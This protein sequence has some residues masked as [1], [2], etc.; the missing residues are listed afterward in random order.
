[1]AGP[2]VCNGRENENGIVSNEITSEAKGTT[3]GAEETSLPR[4]IVELI[5][6]SILQG[7]LSPGEHL[8]QSMLASQ[9][10]ISKVPVREALKQLDAEGLLQHDHNRGYF[11]ARLSKGEARQLYRLRRWL[12]R[13]LLSSA[14]WPTAAELAG[15][16][17]LLE[18]VSLPVDR[19]NREV[20]NEALSEM[21][22][23][24]FNLSPEKAL[25]REARRLWNLTDRYRA[26]LP[27]NASPTGEKKLVDALASRDR[28]R[29]LAEFEQDRIRIESLIEEALDESPH[30][31]GD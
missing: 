16:S 26:L 23:R 9:Y 20:W 27:P 3:L 1:M 14:R 15:L 4:Q 11:V 21:R 10:S 6:K 18:I 25:L 29:L 2:T 28:E 22:F 31:V 30:M 5:R 19:T 7:N 8:N 12:E 24:I 17:S 13:E